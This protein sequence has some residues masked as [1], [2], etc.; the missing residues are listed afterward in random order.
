MINF[1]VYGSLPFQ[2]G[3]LARYYVDLDP[4]V[5]GEDT[6]LYSSLPLTAASQQMSILPRSFRLL[7]PDNL[8]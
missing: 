5:P 1:A 6:G 8:D 3:R 2:F 7:L 4:P